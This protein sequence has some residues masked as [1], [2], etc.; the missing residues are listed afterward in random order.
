[1]SFLVKLS[2]QMAKFLMVL[3]ASWAFVLSFIILADIIG[4]SL[5]NFPLNGVK[6][7]VANSIVMIVFLQAGYAIRSRSMLRA[8]FLIDKFPQ[9][10][11]RISLLLSYFLGLAF[12][13]IVFT[14]GWDLAIESWVEGHYEGE[15]ALHVP[16]W[17]TRFTI[18][19]GSGLSTLSYIVLM[20]LDV[21]APAKI[22]GADGAGDDAEA[23]PS[24]V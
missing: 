1:M 5:F 23:S 15:G 3:A 18:L 4:R 6:E 22:S 11:K 17:P 12:F 8:E 2:D 21:F 16:S 9:Y 13:V 19:I 14:S 20:V 7:I 24:H 10:I